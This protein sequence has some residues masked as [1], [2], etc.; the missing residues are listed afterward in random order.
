MA[1][2]GVALKRLAWAGMAAAN[3]LQSISGVYG[4][5]ASRQL[6]DTPL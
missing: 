3:P 1:Y 6:G 2:T 5:L 4:A